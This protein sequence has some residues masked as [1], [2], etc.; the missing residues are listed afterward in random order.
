[1]RVAGLHV[2]GVGRFMVVHRSTVVRQIG[3][4]HMK[5]P[6]I[7][8]SFLVMM[9]IHGAHNIITPRR[10]LYVLILQH[11]HMESTQY[12]AIL[13]TLHYYNVYDVRGKST[14][15]C[16]NNPL[17]VV[18]NNDRRARGRVIIDGSA[19]DLYGRE[20]EDNVLRKPFIIV[21]RLCKIAF[22]R[23]LATATETRDYTPNRNMNEHAR[24][25]THTHTHKGG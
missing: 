25:H 9:S 2:F 4:E 3:F 16:S 8:P 11:I 10:A 20:P 12:Y 6:C 22:K 21:G 18:A 13:Y 23:V 7:S 14:K 5:M 17:P 1:M 15:R 24:T 19:L